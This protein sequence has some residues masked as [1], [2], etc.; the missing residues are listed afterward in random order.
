LNFLF[1]E[2]GI[3]V[4]EI[5]ESTTIQTEVLIPGVGRRLDI[6]V[7][8]SD[9]TKIAIENQ[10]NSLDHDHLTRSLAYAVGL[11]VSTVIVIAESHKSEFV[12]VATYLNAAAATL[13]RWWSGFDSVLQPSLRGLESLASGVSHSLAAAQRFMMSTTLLTVPQIVRDTVEAADP[14]F[15]LTEGGE[16][17]LLAWAAQWQ[18]FSS[19]YGG[20]WRWRQQDV[21]LRS[22]DG[23]THERNFTLSPLLGSRLVRFEK[24]AGTDLL[25]FETWRA[26]DTL[27]L[28]QPRYVIF[29]SMRERAAI[30]WGGA[31][32][33]VGSTLRGRHGDALRRNPRAARAAERSISR[34]RGYRGLPSLYDL[35]AAQRAESGAPRVV[36][37][38]RLPA[39]SRRGAAELL[40]FGSVPDAAG[41]PVA[42]VPDPS[43]GS[44]DLFA[45]A[46]AS[47]RFLRL[48]PRRDGAQEAPS[49]YSPY[50]RSTLAPLSIQDRVLLATLDG[51]PVWLAG[52]P[53]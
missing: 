35:S 9:G 14:R 1:Q 22:L 27:S 38:L 52:V 47:T 17:Q 12:N 2:C 43:N 23:F 26:L 51:T 18:N 31:D 36:V 44:G 37:R 34:Q 30:A 16:A 8:L 40:G 39:Q 4:E 3:E 24:R 20:S 29:G 33:G 46:A 25:D 49:L 10:F 28:H 5:G 45:E 50:W 11:D 41:D 48:E 53:R 7:T 19:F 21:L 42:L 6:L 32:N 13:Q 15:R